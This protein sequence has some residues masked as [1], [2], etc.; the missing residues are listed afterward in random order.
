[1]ETLFNLQTL[2]Q[3]QEAGLGSVPGGNDEPNAPGVKPLP[4]ASASLRAE[5]TGST[6]TEPLGTVEQAEVTATKPGYTSP[7][8]RQGRSPLSD[9][10]SQ[11]SDRLSRRRAALESQPDQQAKAQ[12]PAPAPA[13]A[14]ATA[15]ALAHG[16]NQ[17]GKKPSA[18][19]PM[20][21]VSTQDWSSSDKRRHSPTR[22]TTCYHRS[23][24]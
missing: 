5:P 16:D 1:M 9:S 24:T 18:A 10:A 19:N 11:D 3:V 2:P 20:I 23:K 22:P 7:P 12:A 8:R 21:E 14:I 15:P 6:A 17:P 4:I 13:P